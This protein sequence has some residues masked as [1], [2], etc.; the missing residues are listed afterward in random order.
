GS[1]ASRTRTR[2]FSNVTLI[3]LALTTAGSCA[4]A[5]RGQARSAPRTAAARRP[6]RMR[7]IVES[8]FFR[9]PAAGGGHIRMQRTSRSARKET[10]MRKTTLAAILLTLAGL[11]LQAADKPIPDAGLGRIAWFDI[12]TTSVAKSQDFYG[13]LFGWTFTP[14]TGAGPD[15]A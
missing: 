7:T 15:Q 6:G 1:V 8:S 11:R 2:S 12:T 10:A 9:R 14:V 4:A 3:V 13:K 5:F